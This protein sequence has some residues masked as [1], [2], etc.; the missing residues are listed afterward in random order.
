MP[1]VFPAIY[2]WAVILTTLAGC[3]SPAKRARE[4]PAAYARLTPVGQRLVL[5]GHLQIGMDR[6]AVLIAWGEPDQKEVVG[7]PP[8]GKERRATVETW[9]YRHQAATHA[10]IGSYDQWRPGGSLVPPGTPRFLGPGYGFG[11]IGNEGLLLYHPR[12]QF[13]ESC[14]RRARFVDGKLDSFGTWYGEYPPLP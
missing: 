7:S 4:H 5:R 9:V 1:R 11:N 10:P 14:V 8:N 13:T 3:A 6:E 2:L 12:V